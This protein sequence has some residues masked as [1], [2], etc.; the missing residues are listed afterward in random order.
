V[1]PAT[2]WASPHR[3]PAYPRMGERFRLRRDFD[4]SS[5]PKHAQAILKGLQTHGMF[6]ADN[7]SDWLMSIAPDRRLQGLETLSRVKGSDFEIVDTSS[8][9]PR[10][11]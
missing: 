8:L 5:F 3:D 11:P 10:S 7:G 2:H 6:V 1:L 4:V 9:R